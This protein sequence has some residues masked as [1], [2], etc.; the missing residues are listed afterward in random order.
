MFVLNTIF[1]HG[2]AF[3][4]TGMNVNSSLNINYDYI[5]VLMKESLN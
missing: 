2:L 4:G 5:I 1:P 3:S